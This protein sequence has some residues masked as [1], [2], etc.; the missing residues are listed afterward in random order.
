MNTETAALRAPVAPARV[1]N[2]LALQVRLHY[3]VGSGGADFL[4]HV[5]AAR[6]ACQGVAD[7]TLAISPPQPATTHVD[8]WTGNR[9]TR[10]RTGPGPLDISYAATIDLWHDLADPAQLPEVPIAALPPAVLP[11]LYPSRYCP[12]DR[13]LTLARNRFGML[14]P[15]CARVLAVQDWVRSQVAFRS[16]S[17]TGTTSAIDTL[18][19]QVGV[20]RDFAHL[21]IALCR[22]LN[23]PARYVT[24]TDYGADPA[25]GPPD[26]H[27]YVE[28]FLG[29]RW[30]LF[31]PSHTAVPMGLVR[32]ATG[33]DAADVAFATL[34]GPVASQAPWVRAT[35]LEDAAQ[36]IVAPYLTDLMLSTSG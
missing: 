30:W 15:G 17:S 4:F 12:S 32:F 10:L 34:F 11:Y 3:E 18:V 1:H 27:A 13:L 35:A 2:R 7:E 31:D 23:L 21:M 22:A 33:R 25:L 8:P 28:V 14:P 16:G 24:G 6:T 26:F 29:D 36:G 20:C 19:E 9:C 5:H